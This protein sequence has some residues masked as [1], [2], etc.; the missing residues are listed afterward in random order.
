MTFLAKALILSL[1]CQGHFP[2]NH[3]VPYNPFG[4]PLIPDMA[5]DP[6]I[7]V[8]DGTFYCYVTTDGY[9]QGLETSGPPVVWKS[10][11]FVNWSFEGT[12]FPQAE[13]EKYWAPSQPVQY[14]G[15]WYTYPTV[16]GYMYPA[17]ADSPDGP[18]RLVKV[19]ISALV[20]SKLYDDCKELVA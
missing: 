12:Y 20:V 10:R 13:H 1:L 14:K 5:G 19:N 18:F 16:N 15:K 3:S 6:S 8:H 17:V 9:G 7:I 11:D 2:D 4:N